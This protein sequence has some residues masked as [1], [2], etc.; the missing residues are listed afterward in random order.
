MWACDMSALCDAHALPDYANIPN[1]RLNIAKCYQHL[2]DE[3][4]AFSQLTCIPAASRSV[5]MHRLIGDLGAKLHE[6]HVIIAAS[7][8]AVLQYVPDSCGRVSWSAQ[9][10]SVR[11][12][13][14]SGDLCT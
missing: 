5:E 6:P 14:D 10:A 12:G 13:A 7:Y 8:L 3:K 9:S 1:L 4:E 11:G 2:G